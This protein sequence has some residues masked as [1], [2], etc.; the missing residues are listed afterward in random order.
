MKFRRINVLLVATLAFIG[1]LAVS[2]QADELQKPLTAAVSSEQ[3]YTD[4]LPQ[5]ISPEQLESLETEKFTFQ[6]GIR[7][8]ILTHSFRVDFSCVD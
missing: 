6:V 8:S 5:D 1:F 7:F 4:G 2:V 3:A